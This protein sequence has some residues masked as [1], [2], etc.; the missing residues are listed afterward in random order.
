M[1]FR[2][3]LEKYKNGTAT[4]EELEFIKGEIEKYEALTD[5]MCEKDEEFPEDFIT[6]T[7]VEELKMVNKHVN[8]KMLRNIVCSVLI[9][10][11]LGVIIT[12]SMKWIYYNPNKGYT[13]PYGSGNGQFFIDTEAFVE[14]QCPGYIV[15]YAEAQSEGFGR[16]DIKI[17]QSNIFKGKEEIYRDK[18]IRGKNQSGNDVYTDLWHFPYGNAFGGN[19]NVSWEIDGKV[20]TSQPPDERKYQ[21]DELKK[22]PESSIVSAYFGF[23]D[24]LTLK[25]FEQM[26]DKY[27]NLGFSYA[28]VNTIET[29]RNIN[30]V[31]FSP[32]GTG[33]IIEKGIVP[34]DEYPYFE[35]LNHGDELKTNKVKVW[36]GHFKTLLKYMSNRPEFLSAVANVNY[37][38]K[39]FY[40]K[41][42][43]YVNANGVCV[44]GVLVHGNVK[45]IL[46][47]E[48]Q[49]NVQSI[50]VNDVKVSTL[51]H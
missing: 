40:K 21:V 31:G 24:I 29:G 10:V 41:T 7:D 19:G 49:S 47:F 43:D 15:N 5:F 50:N 26:Y 13:S 33:V 30:V 6:E 44:Y 1:R 8:K 22:V 25:Q 9:I 27:S 28:A 35:M 48:K 51:S 14:L 34:E 12:F 42:L 20:Y 37:I 36:E 11:V 2:D 3:Y 38:D 32:T 16:Y 17:S 45:D 4:P 18:I 46:E 23:K 39:D